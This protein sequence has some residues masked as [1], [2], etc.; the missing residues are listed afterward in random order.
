MWKPDEWERESIDL[1]IFVLW[2]CLNHRW[3]RGGVAWDRSCVY[4]QLKSYLFPARNLAEAITM[5]HSDMSYRLEIST[6]Y[7]TAT[8]IATSINIFISFKYYTVWNQFFIE[9]HVKV[10]DQGFLVPSWC[11][12]ETPLLLFLIKTICSTGK[13]S[14]KKCFLCCRLSKTYLNYIL[15]TMTSHAIWVDELAD[16]M[17]SKEKIN[18]SLNILKK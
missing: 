5:T 4:G 6:V 14:R 3:I 2:R 16:V 11:K 13:N 9:I 17:T 18:K 10:L 7:S 1:L 8:Q 15:Y 12:C